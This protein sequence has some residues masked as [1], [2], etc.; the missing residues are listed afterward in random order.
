MRIVLFA[1]FSLV[2]SFA[3]ADNKIETIQLN[4]RLA[5][6]VLTEIQPFIPKEAIARASNDFIILQATP[7]VI[8]EIKQLI[9]KLDIP[10]Q[11]LTV[12]VLKTDTVLSDSQRSQ[13]SSDILIDKRGGSLEAGIRQW[14]T[15]NSR[16]KDQ[17]YQARGIAGQA[18]M[19]TTGQALPQKEQSLFLSANG[20]LGIQTKTTYI[21]I[22]NGFQAIANILPN[23]QV[24]IQIYPQFATF[25]KRNGITDRSQLFSSIS[26]PVG[27]WLEIGQVSSDKNI[28]QLGVTRYQTHHQQAQFIYIKIDEIF[29]Q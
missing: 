20:D 1:L 19:I 5:S 13:M 27:V 15:N 12:S 28:Q 4:H 26:G 3:F 8:A 29:S 25:S 10:A 9:N 14:S 23:H 6:E 11:N 21:D 7:Q 18:I 17:Q 24:N 2:N 16:N 22:K